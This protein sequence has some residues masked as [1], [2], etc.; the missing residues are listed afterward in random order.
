MTTERSNLEFASSRVDFGEFSTNES[1]HEEI[2]I[3]LTR[4]STITP[5][6]ES[7]S[8]TER[9]EVA[10]KAAKSNPGAVR[11]E[12]GLHHDV[13][14]RTVRDT[15]AAMIFIHYDGDNESLPENVAGQ[16]RK[17]ENIDRQLT[18]AGQIVQLPPMRKAMA[19]L[20]PAG[21]LFDRFIRYGTIKDVLDEN[22]VPYTSLQLKSIKKYL[23]GKPLE[24]SLRGLSTLVK[25]FVFSRW[26]VTNNQETDVLVSK[27]AIFL[28]ESKLEKKYLG[29]SRRSANRITKMGQ[30]LTEM[31][32]SEYKLLRR[33]EKNPVEEYL[34]LFP[35][36]YDGSTPIMVLEA[37]KRYAEAGHCPET[38]KTFLRNV[39]NIS[40]QEE[41]V[42]DIFPGEFYSD[43]WR[44][45][46]GFYGIKFM[47]NILML[48]SQP[49]SVPVSLNIFGKDTLQILK[50]AKQETLKILRKQPASHYAE[51][52][53]ME[54]DSDK[55]ESALAVAKSLILK[56]AAEVKIENGKP[57]T[58]LALAA[59][60]DIELPTTAQELLDTSQLWISVP[61]L[62]TDFIPRA[63]VEE[64]LIRE[65]GEENEPDGFTSF[66]ATQ[67]EKINEIW[68]I[69]PVSVTPKQHN[70]YLNREYVKALLTRIYL[71]GTSKD[72]K[73][74]ITF[75]KKFDVQ[76][77]EK[78]FYQANL[79]AA[80]SLKYQDKKLK[81]RESGPKNRDD[82]VGR[83]GDGTI[84]GKFRRR[85]K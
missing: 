44:V 19:L 6:R 59:L 85:R 14:S 29:F 30:F 12:Y 20:P 31:M 2:I 73:I 52:P 39:I 8:P 80:V 74:A 25:H 16:V 60:P 34:T 77:L 43:R 18:E 35:E 75:A 79:K 65:D 70:Q 81:Q 71:Q 64:I 4:L 53:E 41:K 22:G 48:Y 69:K 83:N 33:K 27:A 40:T 38:L 47:E 11:K 7:L 36:N 42:Q 5:G 54:I 58:K 21:E 72:N 24:E 84:T 26:V 17:L 62:G 49:N 45:N 51:V 82:Y 68:G 37:Y 10:I 46:L 56:R 1:L 32:N 57:E 63:V 13:I 76:K 50:Q 66:L 9:L 55:A 61:E 78:T 67:Q 15:R 28:I 3:Q 23:L